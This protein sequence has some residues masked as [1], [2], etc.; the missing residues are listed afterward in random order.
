MIVKVPQLPWYGDTELEL[1][2]PSSWEVNT[3]HMPGQDMPKLNGE[4]MRAAFL[5]PIGTPRISQLARN[6]KKVVILF[7]DFSRPTKIAEI[8]PYILEELKEGGIKDG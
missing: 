8:V 4:K 6:K 7:D 2:F 1:E 3:C 5:N